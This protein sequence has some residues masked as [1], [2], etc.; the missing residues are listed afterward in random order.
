MKCHNCLCTG[1]A[2][3]II[4]LAGC[5]STPPPQPAGFVADPDLLAATPEDPSLL[6]WEQPGFD[7]RRYTALIIDPV[8]IRLVDANARGLSADEL[9]ELSEEFR[10]IVANVLGADFPIVAAAGP[11]VLRVRCAITDVTAVRPALN[12][13]SSLIAFVPV[14]TGGASIE[15]E[16]LD[17]ETGARLA[18]GIDRKVGSRFDPTSAYSKLGHART[19]F[20]DWAEEL[21][22]ALETN[23]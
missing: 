8:E 11:D 7:W 13:A 20:H 2:V 5:A 15:V 1:A 18:A 14:D 9:H 21:R 10:R 17:S 4:A 16:F 23:P 19:A 22:V 6:W 12:V 3:A